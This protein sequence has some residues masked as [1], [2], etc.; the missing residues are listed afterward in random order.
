MINEFRKQILEE[1]F[2]IDLQKELNT[3]TQN[4]FK[5]RLGCHAD[6]KYFLGLKDDRLCSPMRQQ[7]KST[8]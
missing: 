1:S 3:V 2:F 5:T 8:H 6:L 4:L 7:L